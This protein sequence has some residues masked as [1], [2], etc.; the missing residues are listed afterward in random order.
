MRRF[1]KDKHIAKANILAE[2]RYLK[3]KGLISENTDPIDDIDLSPMMSSVN[4]YPA[5]VK[6]YKTPLPAHRFWI[7]QDDNMYDEYGIS[8][9]KYE[10]IY[11]E[12]YK[13]GIGPTGTY[14]W[15]ITKTDYTPNSRQRDKVTHK[16]DD[17][18]K[19]AKTAKRLSNNLLSKTKQN[20][21]VMNEEEPKVYIHKRTETYKNI[22]RVTINKSTD[23]N[24]IS[25]RTTKVFVDG[26]LVTGQSRYEAEEI[27]DDTLDVEVTDE[28]NF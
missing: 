15:T 7:N 8:L 16:S 17:I 27:L 12:D 21:G 19:I 18:N 20:E 1:D 25:K 14:S 4:Q 13:M 2:Q 24:P 23:Q 6:Y 26:K 22:K 11:K 28:K 5:L 3:S 9:P 10:I